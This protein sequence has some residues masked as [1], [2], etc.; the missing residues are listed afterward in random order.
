MGCQIPDGDEIGCR[1]QIEI[2]GVECQGV[3]NDTIP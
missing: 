3:P 2:G 1:A